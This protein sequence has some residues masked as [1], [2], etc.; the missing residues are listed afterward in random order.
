MN[1]IDVKKQ[2]YSDNL[3]LWTKVRDCIAGSTQVKSK[4]TAYLPE[5]APSDKNAVRYNNYLLRANFFN[6]TARTL[7]GLIGAV[8]RKPAQI[9]LPSQLE[10]MFVDIDGSGCSIE[11]SAKTALSDVIQIG[12]VGLLTDFPKTF[13]GRAATVA[14]EEA[15]NLRASIIQYSAENIIN[16]NTTKIGAETV[17]QYVVLTESHSRPK[18]NNMLELENYT[19][20]RLLALDENGNYYQ[21]EYEQIQSDTTGPAQITFSMT[22]ERVYPRYADGS[23][24]T[25]IPFVFIG[26]KDL[27]PTVDKAP[28]LDLA[29]INLA[30]YRNSADYEE[31][32]YMAGQPTLIITGLTDSW[33]SQQWKGATLTVGSRSSIQLPVGGDAKFAQIT[34]TQIGME[35]MMQ[36][37]QQMIA[38]GARFVTINPSGV[39]AA[40]TVKLRQSGE[41]SILSTIVDNVEEGYIIALGYAARFMGGDVASIIFKLNKDFFAETLTPDEARALSEMWQKGVYSLSVLRTLFRQGEL[42]REDMTDEEI[43]REIEE[44]NTLFS[45]LPG[46]DVGGED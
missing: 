14:E 7:E 13:E 6:A 41:V 1:N 40:E 33:I 18:N 20:Y 43:D 27:K 37:Q 24:L 34:P 15:L 36:K 2:E 29:E 35:A 28:L 46:G 23:L 38:I 11:Q 9:E 31:M 21:E 44:E 10:Y 8:W 12:R 30:H 32:V 4:T 26:S 25:R 19:L 22:S 3:P 45:G 16:W 42:I 5:P 39:E 17:L